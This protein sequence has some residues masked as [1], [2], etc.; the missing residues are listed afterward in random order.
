MRVCGPEPND[1][2]NNC[3]EA[4]RRLARRAYPTLAANVQDALAKE[5]FLA[6]I[7]SCPVQLDAR[8]SAPNS[9]NE[10]LMQA[11]Q[12]Q[13]II[14]TEDRQL[15][16]SSLIICGVTD[17]ASDDT[18]AALQLILGRRVNVQAGLDRQ[19]SSH[20]EW[21]S[22]LRCYSCGGQGHFVA[23]CPNNSCQNPKFRPRSSHNPVP[24][25][26]TIKPLWGSPSTHKLCLW[27]RL[28]DYTS[29]LR[30]RHYRIQ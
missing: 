20:Q 12:A 8:R 15:E 5:Q 27:C 29:R 21:D 25:F 3:C 24:T 10:A 7:T 30:L 17:K 26:Y 2:E 16:D 11:L 22:S 4:V 23:S 1:P 14:A 6:G 9:L 18:A 13:A 19:Q 28:C